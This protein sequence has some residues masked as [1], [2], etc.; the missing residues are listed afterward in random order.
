MSCPPQVYYKKLK[1]KPSTSK[2]HDPYKFFRDTIKDC[3]EYIGKAK[4][5]INEIEKE[6]ERAYEDADLKRFS[7]LL[8]EYKKAIRE[9]VVQIS[10]NMASVE[11][12]RRFIKLTPEIES[13]FE[14]I[15]GDLVKIL[16]NY[17]RIDN[18]KL[19]LTDLEDK[20][21]LRPAMYL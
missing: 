6:L 18:Y 3:D 4:V 16:E 12:F 13:E 19:L 11:H 14:R 21:L 1:N 2:R 20:K 17:K 7:N 10:Y 15:S 9:T 8:D 5:K